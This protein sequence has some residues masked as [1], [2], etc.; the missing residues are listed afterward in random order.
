MLKASQVFFNTFK[1]YTGIYKLHYRKMK[2]QTQ[3]TYYS[4]SRSRYRCNQSERYNMNRKI[5]LPLFHCLSSSPCFSQSVIFTGCPHLTL[6][7]LRCIFFSS[8]QQQSRRITS[9]Q[10]RSASKVALQLHSED[11]ERY[12]RYSIHFF[13]SQLLVFYTRHLNYYNRRRVQ[14]VQHQVASEWKTLTTL[15]TDR[16]I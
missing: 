1:T 4:S 9:M 14:R 11:S 10:H 6:G 7:L 12:R 15:T 3:H 8:Y 5:T 2:I 16:C 13:L